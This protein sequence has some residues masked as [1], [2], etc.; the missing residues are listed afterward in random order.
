[1]AAKINEDYDGKFDLNFNIM[2]AETRF[3]YYIEPVKENSAFSWLSRNGRKFSLYGKILK[4]IWD[5]GSYCKPPNF[6]MTINQGLSGLAFR[7]GNETSW[8][9][10]KGGFSLQETTEADSTGLN[11]EQKKVTKDI[12][13]AASC[14]LVLTDK[15]VNGIKKRVIGVLNVES[16]S[17]ASEELLLDASK[18]HT[19]YE[20]VVSLSRI[21]LNL[22][23]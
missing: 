22:H 16:K 6:R 20:E 1:M 11:D 18:K 7:E 12:V 21:Y 10:I 3:C 17:I 23:L 4:V 8:G 14:P 13:I 19:F 2:L 15:D 9:N 5:H